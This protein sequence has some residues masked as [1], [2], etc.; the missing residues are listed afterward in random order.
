[1]SYL[2]NFSIE[3]V[4]LSLD[5]HSFEFE[6][7]DKFFTFFEYSQIHCSNVHLTVEL[8][9]QERMM[10]LDFTFAGEVEITCDRCSDE[11]MFPINV[12]EQLIVKFGSEHT[13]E[14]DDVVVLADTEYQLDL[15]EYI[16]EYIHLALPIKVIHPDDENGNSGCNPEVL[17]ILN[18]VSVAQEEVDPRW[19]ALKKLKGDL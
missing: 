1:M 6:I 18:S 11:F 4:G 16:Y 2:K 14:S 13:E 5:N 7:T 9:K 12:T 19:E 8:Q 17:R 15:S 3:Y 10:I